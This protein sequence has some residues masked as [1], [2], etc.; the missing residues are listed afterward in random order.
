[1][2]NEIWVK[3]VQ[4]HS[5]TFI[6]STVARSVTKQ[7]H[8][9]ITIG[10][11]SGNDIQFLYSFISGQHS[12]IFVEQGFFTEHLDYEDYSTYGSNIVRWSK[13]E[14]KIDFVH[15]KKTKIKPGDW[16]IIA[17]NDDT[18]IANGILLIPYIR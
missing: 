5:G 4:I 13:A 16:I 15:K 8:Q 6:D 7:I 10:R 14:C 11:D 12:R 9:A 17:Y 18:G 1:M 2:P 3:I